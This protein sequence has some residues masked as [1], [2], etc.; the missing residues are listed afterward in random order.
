M[1]FTECRQKASVY[2]DRWTP[3]KTATPLL[4]GIMTHSVLE[5]LHEKQ[6]KNPGYVPSLQETVNVTRAVTKAYEKE[7]GGRWNEEEAQNFEVISAQIESVM[8][9]YFK[10]WAKHPLKWIDVEGV[11]RIPFQYGTGGGVGKTWLTGRFDGVYTAKNGAVWLFDAKNKSQI[12]EEQLG[13]TL[14]RDFQI[15]FYLL[16]VKILTGKVPAGFL[17]SVARRPNLKLKQSESIPEYAA[18][19]RAHIAED[20][21]HYFKRYEVVVDKADLTAFEVE[22]RELVSEFAAWLAAGR[23]VRLFG[24]PCVG[25]YGMCRNVPFCY[26]GDKAPFMKRDSVFS[27]L[28]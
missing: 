5:T 14:L 15:N 21:E 13:E 16:A 20:P 3:I 18:R 27:E 19:I 8:P 7:H 22:L 1:M 9:E 28:D 24:Q 25:K 10:H 2:L 11:F 12:V 23:P 17:Y 6:Q 26:N 4:H